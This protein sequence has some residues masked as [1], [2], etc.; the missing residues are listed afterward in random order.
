MK[1]SAETASRGRELTAGGSFGPAETS[2]WSHCNPGARA[3]D[4]GSDIGR[5]VGCVTHVV[6]PDD[7]NKLVPIG[8]IGELL[9]EGPNIAQGYLNNPEKTSSSFVENPAWMPRAGCRRRL[10]R[11]GDMVRYFA[12]GRVQFLGR[13][14]TQVKLRGQRIE[15]GEIEYQLRK[16]VPEVQKFAVEMVKL[17]GPDAPKTLAAFIGMNVPS[18]AVAIAAS[19]EARMRFE[20]IVRGLERR[21][22]AFLPRHMIPRLYIPLTRMPMTLSA[23]IDRKSLRQ[24]ASEIPFE[25]AEQFSGRVREKVLVSTD[26][27]REVQA[28]W[29]HTLQ[30]SLDTI[31]ADADFFRL[32][33]DS[34]AAMRLVSIA[35]NRGLALSVK[36]IFAQPVLS[37]MALTV[38]DTLE[39]LTRKE[40][41]PFT[42]LPASLLPQLVND[43]STLCRV[44]KALIEDVYPCTPLQDGIVALS[45]KEKGTYVSQLVF[46][47]PDSIDIDQFKNAWVAVA[48]Q[49]AI[50]RTRI[51]ASSFFPRPVQ[52]VV[53]GTIQFR[54][55]D[56]LE[57]YIR[58][59]LAEAIGLG[60]PLSRV[61]ASS[62]IP[63]RDFTS[64]SPHIM[65]S[66]ITKCCF[67]SAACCRTRLSW[68]AP[69]ATAQLQ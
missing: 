45:T 47:L 26:R 9:V 32:G 6:D 29:A 48:N 33:G 61:T 63:R 12:D 41:A 40:V 44:D 36:Q 24:I 8:M 21:L 7:W 23:K 43:V 10:Y 59:D 27:E 20:D 53:S 68:A 54:T 51:V 49:A 57:G 64:C 34:V 42:L 56:S 18:G 37:E 14:D 22:A 3:D 62:T 31:T 67:S 30:I 35:R 11:T 25:D 2:I 4:L 28:L 58:S 17:S 19:A 65:L 50:L 1:S 38:E 46:R 66:T 15:L 39:E 69:N 52:V 5:S 60:A 55:S 16:T 13:R